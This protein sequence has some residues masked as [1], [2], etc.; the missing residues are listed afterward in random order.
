[1]F[2]SFKHKDN[3]RQHNQNLRA[4]KIAEVWARKCIS[5][6]YKAA[7]FLQTKSEKLSLNTKR[8]I[9]IAFSIISFSSCVYLVVK[10]FLDNQ[11]INIAITTIEVPEQVVQNENNQ[12]SPLTGVSKIGFEKVKKFRAYLDSLATS[13]SGRRVYDSIVKYRSGLIDSLVFIESFYKSH[14]SNK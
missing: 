3:Q 2:F 5:I 9:V 4:D 11:N 6:Q 8:I 12:V 10:N 14:S 1:M 7:S 13:N